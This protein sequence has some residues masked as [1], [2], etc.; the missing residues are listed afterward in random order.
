MKTESGKPTDLDSVVDWPSPGHR[1]A[2]VA[3]VHAF[4]MIA[5]TSAMMEES[6][7]LLLA[8]FLRIKIDVAIPLIHK[9]TNGTRLELLRNLATPEQSGSSSTA[10]MITFAINCY[11]ICNE[12]RNILVHALH[13]GTD[14][15]TSVMKLSKRTNKNPINAF[16]IEL[17]L[18]ELRQCAEEMANTVNYMLDLYAVLTR[19]HSNT[20]IRRPAR[21]HKLLQNLPPSTRRTDPPRPLS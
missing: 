11:E 9:C 2:S 21:P 8:H 7:S 19:A 3:H 14:R 5:L 10:E 1:I 17:S 12:N 18:P 6:L 13:E 15:I 4:G 16:E 20:L